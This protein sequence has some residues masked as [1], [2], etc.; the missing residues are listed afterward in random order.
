VVVSDGGENNSR[1]GVR[2]LAR[3]AVEPDTQIFAAGLFEKPQSEEEELGPGLLT[4]LCAKTGGVSFV[5]RNVSDLSSAMARIGS[6]LHNQ[7]LL[8]YYP[9]DTSPPGKYRRIRVQ[10]RLPRGLPAL[11]IH[12]RTGYYVPSR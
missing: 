8:G 5:I 9:P 6:T 12:A 10:L 3:L 1:Y 4:R 7:Y 11:Q 2:D